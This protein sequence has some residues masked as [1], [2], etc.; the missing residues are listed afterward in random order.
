MAT[1]TKKYL[2]E[3]LIDLATKQN[4]EETKEYLNLLSEIISFGHGKTELVK[5]VNMCH[6]Y[7]WKKVSS[8]DDRI[9][10]GIRV[11]FT[12]G[13]LD[14]VWSKPYNEVFGIPDGDYYGWVDDVMNIGGDVVYGIT[15]IHDDTTYNLTTHKPELL[16]VSEELSPSKIKKIINA[17]EKKALEKK[18]QEKKE[19]EEKAKDK[20]E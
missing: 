1:K 20:T 10:P 19:R 3:H 15:F 14:S 8:Y 5:S 16:E 11:K 4:L 17:L 18:E 13:S 7:V 6:D 9:Y 2:P 12:L